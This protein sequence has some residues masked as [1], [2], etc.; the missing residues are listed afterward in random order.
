MYLLLIILGVLLIIAGVG[1]LLRRALLWGLILIVLGVI[2]LP[3][4]IYLH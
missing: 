4:G 2:A 3:G 1:A